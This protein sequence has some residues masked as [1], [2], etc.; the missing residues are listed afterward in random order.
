[1][2][3]GKQS[4]YFQ[5]VF[6]ADDSSSSLISNRMSKQAGTTGAVC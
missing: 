3:L 1:M 6:E 2:I 4:D 5:V